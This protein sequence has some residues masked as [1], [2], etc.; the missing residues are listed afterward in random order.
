MLTR[1]AIS[2]DDD[3]RRRLKQTA[4]DFDTQAGIV[5][6]ALVE[7][8]L[9]NLDDP[10]VREAVERAARVETERRRDAAAKG[11]RVRWDKGEEG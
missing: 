10:E 9:A 3:A 2:L 1:T 8:G 7:H 11:G 5:G 4:T 6:R